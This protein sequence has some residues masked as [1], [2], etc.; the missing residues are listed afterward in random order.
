MKKIFLLIF[1]SMFSI[2]L[3]SCGKDKKN[4]ENIK[5]ID[6]YIEYLPE[7]ID[8]VGGE[9]NIARLHIG[10]YSLVYNVELRYYIGNIMSGSE[11]FSPTKENLPRSG[12]LSNE[13]YEAELDVKEGQ[14]KT[15]YVYKTYESISDSR[16]KEP[17]IMEYDPTITNFTYEC[18]R[19]LYHGLNK[20]RI[21][22][23][24][25]GYYG[26]YLGCRMNHLYN[27]TI[28]KENMEIVYGKYD[29]CYYLKDHEFIDIWIYNHGEMTRNFALN[30]EKCQSDEVIDN[31]KDYNLNIED[32]SH[33]EFTS[34]GWYKISG[35]S[36]YELLMSKDQ[37]QVA[38]DELT[39]D[40]Y[41][42]MDCDDWEGQVDTDRFIIIDA[43]NDSVNIKISPVTNEMVPRYFNRGDELCPGDIIEGYFYPGMKMLIGV[44]YFEGVK[45]LS[46]SVEMTYGLTY[47]FVSSDFS[48]SIV[49]LIEFR[50][51]NL[52]G[53]FF[54]TIK[55]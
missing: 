16:K 39:E 25:N 32:F 34:T 27:V 36:E 30:F 22:Y 13:V 29:G 31:T 5:Y 14:H 49:L 12:Y 54:F 1:I 28:L 19:T 40:T 37:Y 21:F 11:S 23:T 41:I 47:R 52:E 48:Y 15:Y 53:E 17:S 3:I 10:D 38:R 2:F 43:I 18:D 42:F 4:T 50:D 45:D 51:P 44:K 8:V 6:L 35:D 26:E 20:L 7:T 9:K 55:E 46:A 24:M 33:I